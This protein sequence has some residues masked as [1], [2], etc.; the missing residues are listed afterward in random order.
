MRMEKRPLPGYGKGPI[1]K[2]VPVRPGPKRPKPGQLG[3]GYKRPGPGPK[4][5]APGKLSPGGMLTAMGKLLGNRGKRN[6]KLQDRKATPR[7]KGN[8]Q[9]SGPN[10]K[11]VYQGIERKTKR[12]LGPDNSKVTYNVRT[13]NNPLQGMLNGPAMTK[14]TVKTGRGR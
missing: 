14:R 3:P 7:S 2:P 10:F 5:P 9:K 12:N 11:G 4:R 8:M 6:E 1:K 13:K